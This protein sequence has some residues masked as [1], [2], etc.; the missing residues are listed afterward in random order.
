VIKKLGKSNNK[1]NP[2]IFAIKADQMQMNLNIMEKKTFFTAKRKYLCA[3]PI[4]QMVR[5]IKKAC[6]PRPMTVV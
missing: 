5:L 4:F 6:N 2:L 1:N 3:H